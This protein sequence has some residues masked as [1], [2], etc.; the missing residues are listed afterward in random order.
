MVEAIGVEF[1]KAC[2][3]DEELNGI[4][5]QRIKLVKAIVLQQQTVAESKDKRDAAK[6]AKDGQ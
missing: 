4:T 2:A 6:K 3:A 1:K 5:A